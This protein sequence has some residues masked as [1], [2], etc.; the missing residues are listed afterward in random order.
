MMAPRRIVRFSLWERGCIVR[1]NPKSKVQSPKCEHGALQRLRAVWFRLC[2][3]ADSAPCL[4]R[5][6]SFDPFDFE[7][8]ESL[9]SF[10]SFASFVSSEEDGLDSVMITCPSGPMVTD[11]AADF[12]FSALRIA[13]AAGLRIGGPLGPPRMIGVPGGI[14]PPGN[15]GG[16]P[17]S[18]PG[19]PIGIPAG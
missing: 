7:S 11:L 8:L 5:C 4:F 12:D 9:E 2:R 13:S 17:P 1:N 18:I 10:E 6:Y 16:G 14:S 19:N 15:I 3:A